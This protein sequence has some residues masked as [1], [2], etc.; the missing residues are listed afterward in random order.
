MSLTAYAELASWKPPQ[1][2]LEQAI[3][4]DSAPNAVPV[5]VTLIVE[6][7]QDGRAATCRSHRPCHHL[8]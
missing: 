2:S 7:M 1:A 5:Q 4:I 3:D 6:P 8:N